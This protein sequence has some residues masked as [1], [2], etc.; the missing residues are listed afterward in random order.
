[1]VNPHDDEWVELEDC[2]IGHVTDKAIQIYHDTE[3]FWVPKSC[4][5]DPDEFE[6]YDEH[7]LVLVKEWFARA[8][9]LI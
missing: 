1:M 6:K 7:C 8:N 3:W 5:Q 4:I 2:Y 9:S